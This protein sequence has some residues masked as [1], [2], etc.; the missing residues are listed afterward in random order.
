[1]DMQMPV[2]DGLEATRQIRRLQNGAAVAI[3]AVTANSFAED[4]L[5]CLDAGMSDFVAKPVEPDDLYAC[6]LKWLSRQI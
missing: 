6:L 1:M 4:R 5:R 2:M 3:L